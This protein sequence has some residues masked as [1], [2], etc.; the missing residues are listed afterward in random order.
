VKGIDTNVLV[1]CLVRDDPEQAVKPI[2]ADFA[3]A[4]IGH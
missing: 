2:G 4:F 1:R 3:D